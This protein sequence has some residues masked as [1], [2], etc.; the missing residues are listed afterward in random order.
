MRAG[1]QELVTG[2]RTIRKPKRKKYVDAVEVKSTTDLTPR[3]LA[4]W[5]SA[6]TRLVA[7]PLER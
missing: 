5:S 1:T 3:I 6:L 7:K 4:S 2:Q